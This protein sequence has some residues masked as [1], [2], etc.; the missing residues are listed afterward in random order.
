MASGSS[1]GRLTYGVFYLP[2][3]TFSYLSVIPENPL[4]GY[5]PQTIFGQFVDP[6]LI[7]GGLA[8]IAFFGAMQSHGVSRAIYGPKGPESRPKHKTTHVR[9]QLGIVLGI[10]ADEIPVLPC[11]IAHEGIFK[12]LLS[13]L[14]F[15]AHRAVYDN[16]PRFEGQELPEMWKNPPPRQHRLEIGLRQLVKLDKLIG[17]K[18][19]LRF[20]YFLPMGFQ[21][22]N[23]WIS[24]FAL[25][26]Y[27]YLVANFD[28]IIVVLFGT[29]IVL[30]FRGT[31]WI[32]IPNYYNQDGL[33]DRF[34]P[35]YKLGSKSESQKGDYKED[36]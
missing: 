26:V 15:R 36:I 1:L 28:Y 19:L 8:V 20:I 31:I 34:I 11:R 2:A 13:Y 32:P 7:F 10:D 18:E 23:I 4:Y 24:F 30:L 22:I 27:M 6:S 17:K 29:H 35:E 33:S 16:R 25:I 21:K 9:H 3:L 14:L 5:L 12:E